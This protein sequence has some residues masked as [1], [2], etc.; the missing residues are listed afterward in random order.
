VRRLVAFSS[1]V[2]LVETIFFSALAPLLPDF[3]TELGL[4]KAEAGLLV[5][6]YAIGGVCGAIPGGWASS[7]IGIRATA[8]IGLVLV[9]VTCVGFGLAET[10][11][12]LCLARFAQGFA[13]SL[14]WNASFAWIVAASPKERRGEMLG[15]AMGAAVGGALLGP[16]VGA[17]ASAFGRAPVFG[18]LAGLALVLAAWAA[19]LPA[20]RQGE[21]QPRRL[22]LDAL[23]ARRVVAAMWLLMLPALL[24][25][26]IGTLAPLQLD[27][28][29]WGTLGIGV[30]FIVA[31]GLE[32]LINP[33]VGRWSDRSG[34][35]APIRFGLVASIVGSLTIPWVDQRLALSLV[36]VC[37]SVA[38]GLFWAPATAL[39][40][41][42]FES[43]GIEAALG[44]A[45][46]NFAW[47]PGHI[48]GSAVGG[49]IAD[50]GGDIA[51]YA[52]AAAICLMT[53]VAL[54][55]SDR[56]AALVTATR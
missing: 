39:L 30:T 22:L 23:R 4:S 56:P 50:L 13:A 53:L 44:F 3:E 8:V 6:M 33:A 10:Y 24:I 25:G 52:F 7:R 16:A 5:S 27:E 48:V 32:A 46:M 26:T 38:Y 15:I 49:G 11:G 18:G 54:R 43:I 21:S 47:A 14:C 45:L 1:A 36:V 12:L 17:A 28:V 29:G 34:R 37:A 9:A 41:D 19:I 31:A 51:A 35:L 55:R 42:G 2:V 40:S 20:P